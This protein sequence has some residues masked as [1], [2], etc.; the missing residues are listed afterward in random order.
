M[1]KIKCSKCNIE[2]ATW[3]Y[4]PS[5]KLYCDNCVPRGCT[6]NVYSLKE[7]QL[8]KEDN[9]DYIFWNKD[10]TK[11]TNEITE[12]SCYY[13]IVDEK[14]RRFPCC[15]YFYEEDGFDEEE[16]EN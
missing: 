2:N 12:D 13:E 11:Y 16:F 8:K 14:Y 3:I 1:T 5:G 15:E 10:L 6:C 7:F 4:M 9:I